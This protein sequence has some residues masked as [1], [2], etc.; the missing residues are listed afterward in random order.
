MRACDHDW[1]WLP[2]P[3]YMLNERM[4]VV[5]VNA[6]CAKCGGAAW[7]HGRMPCDNK[8]PIERPTPTTG[9]S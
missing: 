7:M 2:R 6:E 5:A 8:P 9:R 4:N 1:R 3:E